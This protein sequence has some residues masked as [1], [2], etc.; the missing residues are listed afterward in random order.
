[1]SWHLPAL[2]AHL[3][4]LLL[5][6]GL[7]A[8]LFA[9]YRQRYLG[10]WTASWVAYLLR[11]LFEIWMTSHQA[12]PVV[13]ILGQVA[14]L[15]AGMLLAAGT[16]ALLERRFHWIWHLMGGLCAL[17]IVAATLGGMD[18]LWITLPNFTF[19][20]VIY[21]WTGAAVM[22]SS[23][24]GQR[25]RRLLGWS[26][27]VWG[28]HKF[29]YPFLLPV[30]W[31]APWGFGLGALLSLA[32]ALGLLLAFFD[33]SQRQLQASRRRYQALF[34]AV[35]DG[36][37]IFRLGPDRAPQPYLEVNPA[38]CRLLGYERE[39][40]LRRTARDN[41]SPGRR[42]EVIAEVERL[43]AEDRLI[44]ETELLPKEGPPLP[45]EVSAQVI[46]LDGQPTV[47]AAVRD[48]RERRRAQELAA[49]LAAIVTA[50]E[51]AI[52]SLSIAG[53]I[54]TWNRG[55]E[56]IYGYAAEEV[57]GRSIS[58][59]I[60]E[61]LPGQWDH[62]RRRLETGE[63]IRHLET[64]RVAKDGRRVQVALSI[65][66]MRDARG[67]VTR[68]AGIARDITS[69]RLVEEE[70]ESMRAQ[71]RQ[72]QKMEAVGTLA[73]GIAHDFNNILAA[74]LGYTEMALDSL[75]PDA[76]TRED[77][78]QVIQA[79]ERARDLVRQILAFSRRTDQTPL[80]LRLGPLLAEAA[81]LLRAT[82]PGHL[83]LRLERTTDDDLVRA[84]PTQLHQV[85]LNLCTNAAQ[86]LGRR[87]GLIQV[88][89]TEAGPEEA[90]LDS[91]LEPSLCL[92]VRDD[93]P[94]IPP[95]AR[96]RV[97]D[98]FFTTKSP[99]EGTGL[100][101][102]VAH[103][104]V[105]AHGGRIE[106]ES[107][108]GQ[109]A[110]FRV[111]L[112]R[113]RAEPGTGPAP[114]PAPPG[115]CE[116]ILLV[117]DEAALVMITTRILERLGYRVSAH[118]SPAQALADPTPCDLL[119]T[120]LSMPGLTGLELA[121]ALRQRRPGLPVILCTGYGERLSAADL[122]EAGVA[123]VLTK[124]A[125]AAQLGLAVRQ[126]LDQAADHRGQA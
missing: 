106:V 39:E 16:A 46:E 105:Q 5:L 11:I 66:P 99:G 40:L 7:Y 64:A 118:R 2:V 30:A 125:S 14:A 103:G 34:E 65:S 61:D 114:E 77:L 13:L 98:P 55:A 37:C 101:L 53:E 25:G 58:I 109:G 18:F 54:L 32:V 74:I 117:D 69:A 42:G 20:G 107:E 62:I 1:M 47:V 82:L 38:Y 85:V 115:G 45:V 119:L 59:L 83:E 97:F 124:P 111:F 60:P 10:L 36:I 100:G 48:I 116:R 93:G 21:A 70:R 49:D 27:I 51:D 81:K 23:R 4:A 41:L 112:P 110:V 24:L 52:L 122:A 43:L 96:E 76:P 113:C 28:L 15:G 67:R 19:Q 126:V 95:E 88:S 108:P 123:R 22:G 90:G 91:D 92:S 71:L 89:L 80:P 3:L 87:R 121:Q 9:H 73:G 26:L 44:F 86:A 56:R 8:F 6:L 57:V 75:D 33:L 12:G 79:G 63:A 17:W 31:F 84:D 68:V 120:D 102:A 72:A 104:I 35:N 29:N 94:G 50:S 78:L